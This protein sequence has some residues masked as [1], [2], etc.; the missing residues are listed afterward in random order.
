MACAAQVHF[1]DGK[2]VEL[3]N[4]IKPRATLYPPVEIDWSSEPGALYTFIMDG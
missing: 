3:G 4:D 1:A 2:R